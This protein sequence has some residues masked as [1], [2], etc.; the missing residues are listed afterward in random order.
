LRQMNP[1]DRAQLARRVRAFIPCMIFDDAL[2]G[3]RQD[4][5]PLE[6]LGPV[7]YVE[8]S[9]LPRAGGVVR[10]ELGAFCSSVER[11][12]WAKEK[13]CRWDT[14]TCAGVTQGGHLVVLRWAREHGCPWDEWACARAAASGHLE[15]LRWA[16]EHECPWE[17]EHTE[18]EDADRNCCALAA[19]GGHLEVLKWLRDHDSPWN[20]WTCAVA[21]ASGQLEV[22]KWARSHGCPWEEL[23]D[24]GEGLGRVTDRDCCY[25]AALGGHL[26]VLE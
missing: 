17:D 23:E 7:G 19:R 18:D 22:L 6:S 11:L 26:E 1:A 20:A 25:L 12:A 5:S 4:Y 3:S 16:W 15:V 14:W 9:N 2:F 10:L 13:G 8:S 21:A 24:V